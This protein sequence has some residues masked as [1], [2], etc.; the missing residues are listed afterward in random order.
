V[1]PKLRHCNYVSNHLVVVATSF[2][3]GHLTRDIGLLAPG[4][5]IL[6]LRLLG[7]TLQSLVFA[8]RRRALAFVRTP[9][10]FVRQLLA[11]ICDTV[12]LVGDPISFGGAPLARF[13]LNL[14]PHESLLA[15]IKR[16]SPPLKLPSHIGMA[17]SD[18]NSP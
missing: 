6:A 8:R 9:F 13:D 12:P 15:L 18:H 11:L 17:F 10:S 5:G 4:T 2:H 1:G 14:T 7:Y 16:E 3:A